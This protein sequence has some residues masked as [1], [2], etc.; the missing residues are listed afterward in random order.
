VRGY[1]DGV[2]RKQI[3]EQI[4][5]SLASVKGFAYRHGLKHAKRPYYV[6]KTDSEAQG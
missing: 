3:A 5:M 6:R 2:P 1:A 4:G